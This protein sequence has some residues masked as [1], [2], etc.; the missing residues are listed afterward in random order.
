MSRP[1][2]PQELQAWLAEGRPVT[3]LDVR[4]EDERRD[5]S[6]PGSRHEDLYT[7]LHHDGPDAMSEIDLPTD[8]PVVTVCAAGRTSLVAAEGLARRGFEAYSL[9]GGMRAWS[10]TWN[11][12]ITSLDSGTEVVQVRRT[13]KGCLSYLAFSDGEAVAIDAALDPQVFLDLAAER[14]ARIVSVL[15]THVHADHLSRSRLLAGALG[16]PLRLPTQER[17][18]YPFEPL[19]DGDT[20]PFGSATLEVLHT[21]GH[22]WESSSYYLP[23]EAVFTGDTLFVD[24][25]GRPD[26]EAAPDE[27]ERRARALHT[28]IG[29]LTRLPD[30]VLVLPGHSSAPLAFD[31]RTW[32]A[33]LE[34]VRADSDLLGLD[35]DAFV[36]RVT[37]RIPAAPENHRRIV[38]LNE[39]GEQPENAT[40]LEAGGNRC[41][42][43]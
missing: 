21:P 37:A 14:K 39:A 32:G 26:L 19:E 4:P 43:G 16:V 2:E 36:E 23:G 24:S 29:R 15:D 38:E 18:T 42:I 9:A 1:I 12:A 41:A 5:W 33:P 30:E 8:R 11:T 17:V 3:I 27:T 10:H 13:G 25:V 22:T 7:R 34:R 31:G 20:V 35:E 6:I 40:D 28:S